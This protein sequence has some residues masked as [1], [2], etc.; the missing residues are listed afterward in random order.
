[1]HRSVIAAS[2]LL[3][4]SALACLDAAAAP[5]LQGGVTQEENAPLN[6]ASFPNEDPSKYKPET[7]PKALQ[8][9]TSRCIAPAGWILLAQDEHNCLYAMPLPPSPEG[10]GVVVNM[11]EIYERERGGARCAPNP[12]NPRTAVCFGGVSQPAPGTPSAPAPRSGGVTKSSDPCLPFGPGGYDY[13]ANPT[14]P[15]GCNCSK[16]RSLRP[17]PPPPP[18]PGN[19]LV[20]SWDYVRG[21]AQGF[22]DCAQFGMDL[23]AAGAAFARGDF[24]STA[25]ILGLEPGQSVI[26]RTI[27]SELTAK[28]LGASPFEAGRL[29]GRRICSYVVVPQAIKGA[30]KFLGKL[31]GGAR[32]GAALPGSGPGNP[33]SGN[34]ISEAASADTDLPPGQQILP[35]K[36]IQTPQGPVQLG[37][38]LGAGK[39]GNVYQ[40]PSEPAQV[41]K[42]GNAKPLTPASFTRQIEGANLLKSAGVATPAIDTGGAAAGAA[43]PLLFME[44]V[45]SKWPGAKILADVGELQPAQLQAVQKL[46]QQIGSKGLVWADGN[47]S[48]IFVYP[49]ANGLSAGVVDADMVFEAGA[50]RAQPAIV[51]NNLINVLQ[52]VGKMNLIFGPANASQIMQALFNARFGG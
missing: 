3:G 45:F 7:M 39:F 1:M 20:D 13:C 50:L 49:G 15:F 11:G 12:W 23:Y 21:L 17:P 27:A 37:P 51:Q 10:P 24:I 26:L 52:S 19:P 48:N 47:P 34:V 8:G 6:P 14:Q 33:L 18:P 32:A 22:G 42:V 2:L 46:Y 28:A 36:W 4:W 16:R 5:P 29:A 41:I 38:R 31:R 44:N 9:R 35:G 25:Q 30:G 40:L 43:P